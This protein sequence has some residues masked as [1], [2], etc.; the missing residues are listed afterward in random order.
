[1][2]STLFSNVSSKFGTWINQQVGRTQGR[3][4][5]Q[6]S[7]LALLKAEQQGKLRSIEHAE[8]LLYVVGRRL[9]AN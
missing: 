2:V 4:V 9:I 8:K 5:V 1:M 7:W 3:E 6:G